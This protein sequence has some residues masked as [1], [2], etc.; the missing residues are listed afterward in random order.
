V[1]SRTVGSSCRLWYHLRANS[2]PAD[3]IGNRSRGNRKSCAWQCRA[4]GYSSRRRDRSAAL[5]FG[6]WDS[7]GPRGGLGR[8]C[9]AH[10]FRKSWG[11]H[12]IAAKSRTT[13][14]R[15]PKP[16]SPIRPPT[17]PTSSLPLEFPADLGNFERIGGGDTNEF[18]VD[19]RS[20]PL[21]EAPTCRRSV[22]RPCGR[23]GG[24]ASPRLAKA[25]VGTQEGESTEKLG[26]GTGLGRGEAQGACSL[27]PLSWSLLRKPSWTLQKPVSVTKAAEPGSPRS[28]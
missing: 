1:P 22:G 5:L 4:P 13:V 17:P 7:T 23:A 20:Q 28:S 11:T 18:S 10:W 2:L 6:F 14:P 9:S 3:R 12:V 24:C 25:G 26:F 8:S 27:C 15:S 21:R 16:Q 19:H